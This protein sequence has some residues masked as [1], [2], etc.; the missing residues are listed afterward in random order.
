MKTNIHSD[1][2][3][4]WYI[5]LIKRWWPFKTV[6]IVATEIRINCFFFSCRLTHFFLLIFCQRCRTVR[7]NRKFNCFPENWQN[8]IVKTKFCPNAI[9]RKRYPKYIF[10]YRSMG[11][12]MPHQIFM[13]IVGLFENL[14]NGHSTLTLLIPSFFF[15][16]LV[17]LTHICRRS[18]LNRW[19]STEKCAERTKTEKTAKQTFCFRNNVWWR[20]K[21]EPRIELVLSYELFSVLTYN[22]NL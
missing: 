18:D 14:F 12:Q 11:V 1:Y 7:N 4:N 20:E 13:L 6:I 3:T 16:C 2:E 5:Q 9:Y 10:P 19:F 21:K 8:P 22:V 17:R 15:C